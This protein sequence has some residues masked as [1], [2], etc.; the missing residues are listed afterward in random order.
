MGMIAGFLG[1]STVPN[2]LCLEASLMEDDKPAQQAA[3]KKAVKEKRKEFDPYKCN[4]DKKKCKDALILVN[5]Q[6]D[7][8]KRDSNWKG[9]LNLGECAAPDI[10]LPPSA[11]VPNPLCLDT[12]LMELDSLDQQLSTGFK[13][14]EY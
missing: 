8:L 6:N 2:P 13:F 14:D 4:G 1:V 10:S 11:T 7:A 12:S 9:A 5:Q 3:L